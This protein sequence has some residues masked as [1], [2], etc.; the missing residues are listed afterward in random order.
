MPRSVTLPLV[1]VVVVAW[2]HG[3]WIR[4]C[5]AS[6][7]AL[8]CEQMNVVRVFVVDN[9]STTPVRA[10]LGPSTTC[11]VL[12][13]ATN[14]GFAA[15]CNQAAARG[16]G[17]YILFLNPDTRIHPDALARA[18]AVLEAPSGRQIGIVGLRLTDAGGVTQ[19]T[20]GRFPG[21][22]DMVSRMLGLSRIAPALMG[23]V[24]LVEWPHDVSRDVDFACGA[25]LLVR[26]NVFEALGGFEERLFLYLED[27][28]LSLR[29]RAAGWRTHFCADAV[30]EHGCGW[31]T[32]DRRG[33]RLAHSWRS[34]IVYARIHLPA[35]AAAIVTTLVLTLGPLARLAGAAAERS[36]RGARD[37]VHAWSLLC[38]ML[39][40]EVAS[41]RRRAATMRVTPA[42]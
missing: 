18:M 40:D 22:L 5:V 6:V 10:V 13:N 26:R 28:D 27:A 14:R 38:R 8:L 4:A 15:A 7:D 37:A 23:G 36:W 24:R 33:W 9:A 30:V 29:A 31:S 11:T 3:R 17:D 25:A 20:C 21:L 34:L 32:G 2:N 19:R 42:G 41:R 39:I 35:T 12:T 1:D 16:D